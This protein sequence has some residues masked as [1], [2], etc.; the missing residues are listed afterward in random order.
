MAP[1][2]QKVKEDHVA[3]QCESKGLKTSGNSYFKE[4][5]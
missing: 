5:V 4:K 3:I 1:A 2:S